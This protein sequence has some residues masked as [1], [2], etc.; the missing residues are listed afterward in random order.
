MVM[1][2]I[3][4]LLVVAFTLNF[5]AW[6]NWFLQSTLIYLCLMVPTIDI[7]VTDRINPSLAPA[8][9][10]NVP[11][12]LGLASFTT[13]I[14]DW[15]TRT[16]ETVFVMPGE[17]NYHQRH[18][19][20]CALFDA[21]RNFII[22]DAEFSTNLEEHFKKCLFGD[23]MLYQKS[24]TNLAQSRTSGRHRPG[25]GGALAGMAGAAGRWHV[26][27]FIVTCRQA[28]QMLDAQWA[29][30]IEANAA[31]GEGA[32]SEAEQLAG[33]RQ[34]QARLAD[35]ECRLHGLR[36]QLHRSDAAEH[37]DQ[38]FHAGAQQHG[39]WHRRGDDR[40][41]R[42]DPRRHPGTQPTTRSRSRRWHGCRS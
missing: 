23:V 27:N 21:T 22:R 25:I 5:R 28:Y 8:T 24:L 15:L 26:N 1:G 37:G 39:G 16:A 3:Y 38:R 17:L 42:A 36:Q 35:R 40:H 31:L 41:L 4:S 20:R 18:G 30:M 2:F 9:V 7:K 11:L 12:G 13:Q 34:A 32:L 14:G 33:G 6:L 29:P 19:L 10:S